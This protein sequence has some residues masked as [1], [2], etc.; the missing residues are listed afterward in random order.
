MTTQVT[1]SQDKTTLWIE[2]A[3]SDRNIILITQNG[4][5]TGVNFWQGIG[6]NMFADYSHADER[7]TRFIMP[8]LFA[9][10]DT[11]FILPHPE[12][13]DMIEFIDDCICDYYERD[14]QTFALH[15]IGHW[16]YGA[17]MWPMYKGKA[18][19]MKQCDF[20]DEERIRL[21]EV[22][23]WAFDQ[24]SQHDMEVLKSFAP[25]YVVHRIDNLIEAKSSAESI[26]ITIPEGQLEIMR[27]ALLEHLATMERMLKYP[28]ESQANEM[29]DLR[30]LA[31]LM[32]YDV[33]VTL[34][35]RQ[36][37]NFCGDNGID[38]PQ[39]N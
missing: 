8:S 39:Y 24:I 11:E 2:Y 20:N 32:K 6:E 36:A 3:P 15:S 38:L 30:Q 17:S 12:Y 27:N 34:S 29:F 16:L 19:L 21:D 4:M 35:G 28:T 26:T 7:L 13:D 37:D 1:K 25:T 22:T 14:M 33:K 23:H 18:G 10:F 9:R 5:L 31:S